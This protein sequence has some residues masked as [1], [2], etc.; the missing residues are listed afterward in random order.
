MNWS[1]LEPMIKLFYITS[2]EKLQDSCNC[3]ELPVPKLS[4][5]KTA[6]ISTIIYYLHPVI[7]KHTMKLHSNE[8]L[9]NFPYTFLNAKFLYFRDIKK[10]SNE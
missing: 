2:S 6:I 7:F 4:I 10:K 1:Q 8:A 3:E 5:S 9:Q